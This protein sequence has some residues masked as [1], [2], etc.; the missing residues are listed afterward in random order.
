MKA[1]T[2]RYSPNFVKDSVLFDYSGR[3]NLHLVCTNCGTIY[4]LQASAAKRRGHLS[5]CVEIKAPYRWTMTRGTKFQDGFGESRF[6][7]LRCNGQ[8]ILE[9]TDDSFPPDDLNR[10]QCSPFEL[11]TEEYRFKYDFTNSFLSELKAFQNQIQ[12]EFDPFRGLRDDLDR[13]TP[14]LDAA[15]KKLFALALTT[16]ET[17]LRNA[18]DGLSTVKAVLTGRTP[19]IHCSSE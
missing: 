16:C 5:K 10:W 3:E 4:P 11:V 2:D 19:T 7:K 1:E 6:Y 17:G 18:I 14:Y 12:G 13:A 8:I 15:S 9:V